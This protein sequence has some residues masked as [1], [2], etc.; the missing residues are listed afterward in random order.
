VTITE[1]VRSVVLG[2]ANLEDNPDTQLVSLMH[3]LQSTV[4]RVEKAVL[5]KT[6]TAKTRRQATTAAKR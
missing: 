6:G 3:Q 5:R 2:A 1:Y 4:A